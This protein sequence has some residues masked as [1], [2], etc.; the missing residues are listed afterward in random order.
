MTAAQRT[1]QVA[2]GERSYPIVL[3]WEILDAAGEAVARV[4]K[5]TRAALVTVPSVGRRYGA[6]LARSLRAAGLRVH[7]CEVPDGDATKNL[8]QVARLY[9][10]LLDAGLDRASLVIALGGGRVGDL[11]GFVAATYLRGVSFVQVP[12]T[13]LAMVDSSIGGKVGVNLARGK[14]LVGAFHQPRLVWADVAT[15]R[16]LPRR[17]RAAGLAEVVKTGAIWDAPFFERLEA[18]GSRL[19]DVDPEVLLPV[20]E[21]ACAIKAEVVG[22]DER[23]AGLRM[24]LNFGHTLAHALETLKGYRGLLHGE[25]VAIGMA[26]AARRSET[27]GLAPAGTAERLE[28]LL[29]ALGLPTRPPDFPRRAYLAA[30]AV[31]KKRRDAHIHF[32]VL[33]GIGRAETLPLPAA[34][35]LPPARRRGR[36]R[37]TGGA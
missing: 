27:L 25:A 23:E 31:D 7:R 12:T 19:L 34:E 30:L 17:Q 32:V 33:R 18:W 35:I 24:L 21:R 29:A 15:L 20:L 6:R 14:N 28:A 22:L 11:A 9:D 4:S 5:A 3:G 2:L 37:P 1:V 10:A 36:A 26:F 8:R 13:L 16:T